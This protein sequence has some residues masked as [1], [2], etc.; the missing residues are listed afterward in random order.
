MFYSIIIIRL[1]TDLLICVLVLVHIMN[2]LKNLLTLYKHMFIINYRTQFRNKGLQRGYYNMEDY[3]EYII[4]M[5]KKISNKKFIK[6]IYDL[7]SYL[8]YIDR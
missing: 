6:R 7:V 2:I 4:E 3:T 8:Y 5:V 1:F